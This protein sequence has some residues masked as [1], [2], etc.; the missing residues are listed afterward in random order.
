MKKKTGKR[1]ILAGVACALLMAAACCYAIFCDNGRLITPMDFSQYQF[2]LQD[3]PMLLSFLAVA[4]YFLV[5]LFLLARAGLRKPREPITR[6][7]NPKLG[8]LGLF[9]FFGFLGFYTYPMDGS[10]FPFTFFLFFGFFGFFYEGKMSNTFMDERYWENQIKAQH[11]ANK[12]TLTIIF[13]A[14]LFL[15]QGRLIGSLEYTLIALV[16]IIALS[17]ALDIFLSQY[18]LYRW[19]QKERDEDKED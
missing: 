13:L 12:I 6:K 17:F 11:T 1:L 3:L 4:A 7:I 18:L 16:V 8:W 9:G 14:A 15:G 5:L 10:I 19:D 2:R